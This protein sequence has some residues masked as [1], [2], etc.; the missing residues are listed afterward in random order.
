MKGGAK[1][2]PGISDIRVS[3]GRGIVLYMLRNLSGMRQPSDPGFSKRI[4]EVYVSPTR[5]LL[6]EEPSVPSANPEAGNL[7]AMLVTLPETTGRPTF[8]Y[9]PEIPENVF[10]GRASNLVNAIAAGR[11][12]F[13]METHDIVEYGAVS[14]TTR[15][16]Q[17]RET[18]AATKRLPEVL[19]QRIAHM[20]GLTSSEATTLPAAEATASVQVPTESRDD[21]IL[22]AAL[23]WVKAWNAEHVAPK[24]EAAAAKAARIQAEEALA[25]LKASSSSSS[26]AAPQGGRRKKT[27]RSLRKKRMTRRR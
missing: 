27:R 22:D 20:A 2:K 4:S 25:A 8:A 5:L 7:H 19:Q 18:G 11:V 1:F 16:G 21:A 14:S 12:Q 26:N 9:F 24:G 17:I 15:L 13:G 6:I 3:Y 10:K 23:A